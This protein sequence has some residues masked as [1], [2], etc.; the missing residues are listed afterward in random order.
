MLLAG[1]IY[2]HQTA[3]IEEEVEGDDGEP[4]IKRKTT[5]GDPDC[6]KLFL[7]RAWQLA[8]TNRGVGMVMSSGLHGAQGCTGRRRLLFGRSKL[9][10]LVK[11]DNEMRV[12]PGVHNQFK[13]DLVVFEKGGPTQRVARRSSAAKPKTPCSSSVP[14][15]TTCD[16]PLMMFVG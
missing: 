2:F 9:R 14:T 13:F 4:T 6:F 5:G 3:V 10:A 1:G 11:F 7:E 16:F 8:A 12:F 15:G